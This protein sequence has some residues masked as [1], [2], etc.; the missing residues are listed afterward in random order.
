MTPERIAALV[1]RWARLYTRNLPAPVA[2]RRAREIDADLHDQIEHERAGR[3]AERRIALGI[4]ARMLRGL[5]AD[6]SWR[7]EV[8]ARSDARTRPSR[9]AWR[10]AVRVGV[11]TLTILLVP[12]VAMQ[13]GDGV[14]WSL[15]DFVLAGTLLGAAGLLFELAVRGPRRVAPRAAAC[16]IGIAAIVLGDG[17]D[18]PGLVLF[19]CLVILGAIVLSLRGVLRGSG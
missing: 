13:V 8:I 11:V 10:S 3:I 17:D 16:V 4:A 7:A 1:A 18:A 6:V 19:G 12:F 14:D 2:E 15:A 5:A 9:P